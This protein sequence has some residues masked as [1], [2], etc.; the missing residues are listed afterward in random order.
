LSATLDKRRSPQ[1]GVGIGR[2]MVKITLSLVHFTY[3]DYCLLE[4]SYSLVI[5]LLSLILILKEQSSEVFSFLLSSHPNMFLALTNIFYK[6][7]LCCLCCLCYEVRI[8][9]LLSRRSKSP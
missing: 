1:R 7:S 8:E 9:S 2:T 4:F 5:L 6:L 3:C